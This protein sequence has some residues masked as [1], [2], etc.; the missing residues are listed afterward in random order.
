MTTSVRATVKRIPLAALLLIGSATVATADVYSNSAQWE[1]VTS[2]V[3]TVDFSSLSPPSL[4]YL[5][6]PS[7]PGLTLDGVNFSAAGNSPVYVINDDYCCLTYARGSDT[8]SS[9]ATT[10]GGTV[11][12]ALPANTTA[13]GF[14]LFTVT[15]GDVNGDLPGNVDVVINGST[16]VVGTAT[17][18]NLVFFG[19]TSTDPIS[20][21]TI[22]PE[23]VGLGTAVDLTN[24]SYGQAAAV[25]PEPGSYAALILAFGGV[26]LVVRSR[27]A[28]QRRITV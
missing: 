26:I 12:V 23:Q 17:A 15:L 13:I 25:T 18:P 2:G 19:L 28:K 7:P 10:G 24:F 8:L 4:L 27:R 9:G 16:Y 3:T 5:T 6:Y 20:S 11:V 1:A 21:L 14:N 22:T